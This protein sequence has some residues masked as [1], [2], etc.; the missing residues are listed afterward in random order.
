MVMLTPYFLTL[1]IFCN[2]E[3]QPFVHVRTPVENAELVSGTCNVTRKYQLGTIVSTIV[4]VMKVLK[5]I[6]IFFI[7]NIAFLGI[8]NFLQEQ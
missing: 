6:V 4:T 2:S 5:Y 8:L 7:Y 1:D 3:H